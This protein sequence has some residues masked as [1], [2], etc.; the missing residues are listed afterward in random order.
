VVPE[1]F[2]DGV[3]RQRRCGGALRWCSRRKTEREQDRG[4]GM[5][6]KGDGKKRGYAG[7]FERGRELERLEI[8][9]LIKK[10]LYG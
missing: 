1:G 9:G 7:F 2:N 4:D 3:V 8:L 6:N 5:E 10:L